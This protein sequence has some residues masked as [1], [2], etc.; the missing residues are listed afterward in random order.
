MPELRLSLTC[1]TYGARS[2]RC[3]RC[4]MVSRKVP[5]NAYHIK[6]GNCSILFAYK[7]VSSMLFLIS[8]SLV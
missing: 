1:P 6:C 7:D 4:K 5:A 8:F 2:Y 3:I